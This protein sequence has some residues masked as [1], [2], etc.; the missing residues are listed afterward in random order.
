MIEP[1][2]KELRE[3]L[4]NSNA[5]EGEYSEIAMR[6]AEQAWTMACLCAYDFN[7]K[8]GIS[9]I[10]G[11]HRRLAKRLNPRI[12]GNIRKVK[13]YVGNSKEYRECLKPEL[14]Q[15]E[16]RLLLNPGMY[17]VLSEEGIKKWHIQFEHIHPFE[18]FN[19]RTGRILMNVQRL[20]IDLPLL[21]IH[22]GKEQFEY[23]KWFK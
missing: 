23:Y 20:M 9:Y 15:E 22:E 7:G 14:I 2:E 12:A 3:F 1:S 6:N 21:I 19:G 16:L 18:D 10:L 5:I 11:I 4:I 13:V 8:N 17:P